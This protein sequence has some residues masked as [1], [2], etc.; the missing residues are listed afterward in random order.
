[1]L[2]EG[3]AKA[4]VQHY[5]N[6]FRSGGAALRSL[7]QP[8]SMCTFEGQQFQ[9]ADNIIEIFQQAG[10]AA[11]QVKST[12]VQPSTTPNTIAIVTTGLVTIGGEGNPLLFSEFFQ[13]V[14]MSP[15][16]YYVHNQ[17]FRLMYGE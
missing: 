13:L 3:V 9:G 14:N 12:D 10:P 16:Q 8:Q 15:N 2:A 7:Y 6:T 11:Y 5:Y 17:V 1:M 4:F